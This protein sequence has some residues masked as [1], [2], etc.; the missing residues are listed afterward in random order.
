MSEF[1]APDSPDLLDEQIEEAIPTGS[2]EN[3]AALLREQVCACGKPLALV[4]QARKQRLPHF[5]SRATLRCDDGHEIER[6]FEVTWVF[7]PKP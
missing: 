3:W 2:V 4:G 5:Y 6:L 7:K 1:V